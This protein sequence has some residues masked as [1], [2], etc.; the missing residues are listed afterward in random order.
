MRFA[1]TAQTIKAE[2]AKKKKVKSYDKKVKKLISLGIKPTPN[3]VCSDCKW[4]YI[5]KNLD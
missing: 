4:Y 3:D 5:C 2:N 1:R